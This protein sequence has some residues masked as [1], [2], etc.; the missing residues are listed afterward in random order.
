[1]HDSWGLDVIHRSL[2]EWV[3]KGLHGSSVA[4]VLL[5]RDSALTTPEMLIQVQERF[6]VT[7]ARSTKSLEQKVIREVRRQRT[8]YAASFGFQ[9]YLDDPE[10]LNEHV[11]WLYLH[12]VFELGWSKIASVSKRDVG[13]TTVRE[14]VSPL[15]LL[16]FG[17][18]PKL[19]RGRASSV[20]A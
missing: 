14:S 6:R 7:S 11:R 4:V 2:D 1:M 18:R 12:T 10:A 17:R 9:R 20:A 19:R 5:R 13:E 15:Y 8:A 16:L 3:A